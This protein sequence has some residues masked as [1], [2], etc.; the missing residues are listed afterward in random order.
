MNDSTVPET[1]V[2]PSPA[3]RRRVWPSLV[4]FLAGIIVGAGLTV[5]LLHQ[6]GM[7]A[8]RHPERAATLMTHRLT[9]ELGLTPEQAAS[10]QRTLT[11]DL[12]SMRDT[13]INEL[14]QLEAE[15]GAVLTP[16]QAATWRA[17]CAKLARR[18][19]VLVPPKTGNA[20]GRRNGH[21]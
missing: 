6:V 16:T 14:T 20:N 8:V 11:R 10:I 9:R 17:R 15:V 19:P 3:P 1:T 4:I 21:Y 18:F 12:I 7:R 13:R 2:L 5:A